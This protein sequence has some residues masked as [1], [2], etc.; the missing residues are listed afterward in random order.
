MENQLIDGVAVPIYCPEKTL[1][2]CFK[3]RNKIVST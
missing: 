1:V 2:D 3:F